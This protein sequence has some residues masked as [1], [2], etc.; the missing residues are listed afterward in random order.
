MILR[1][2]PL[3]NRVIVPTS[4]QKS[5]HALREIYGA[6]RRFDMAS[7]RRLSRQD[8]RKTGNTETTEKNIGQRKLSNHKLRVVDTF[9]KRI[10]LANV[11]IK[12][13][14]SKFINSK[15]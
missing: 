7:R 13:Q 11:A 12:Q 14:P 1:R 6:A 3:E 4:G 8:K 2:N 10:N 15:R 9:Q 5:H